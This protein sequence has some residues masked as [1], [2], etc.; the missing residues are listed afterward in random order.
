MQNED[1]QR[2]KKWYTNQTNMGVDIQNNM[3]LLTKK[4]QSR[5]DQAA[6]EAM[7]GDKNRSS[8]LNV[9]FFTLSFLIFPFTFLVN[10][11]N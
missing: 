8:N 3:T 5:N 2:I 11:R 9:S 6:Q 7:S 10:H 1:C 4:P